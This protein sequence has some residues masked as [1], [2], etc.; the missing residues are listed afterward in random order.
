LI[1][2]SPYNVGTPSILSGIPPANVRAVGYSEQLTQFGIL[3]R[4]LAHRKHGSFRKFVTIKSS[5]G[6]ILLLLVGLPILKI[7]VFFNLLDLKKVL[8]CSFAFG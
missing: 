5:R 2:H 7:N 1:A 3:H 6:E 8:D 4:S